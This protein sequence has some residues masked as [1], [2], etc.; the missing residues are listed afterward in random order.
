MMLNGKIA[1]TTGSE[2]GHWPGPG[3]CTSGGRGSPR[4]NGAFLRQAA[5][6]GEAPSRQVTGCYRRHDQAKGYRSYF[7]RSDQ[8]LWSAGH[9]PRKR[10]NLSSRRRCHGR[11]DGLGSVDLDQCF[12]CF[13]GARRPPPPAGEWGPEILSSP[14]QF[15]AIRQSIGNPSTA[16]PSTPFRLLC[17]GYAVRAASKR[18]AGR[19]RGPRLGAE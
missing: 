1:V 3:N 13:S 2:F 14:A 16:R 6:F 19:S 9:P 7:P 12:G 18:C 11:A 4:P 10:R 8:T 17:T 5:R 15:L